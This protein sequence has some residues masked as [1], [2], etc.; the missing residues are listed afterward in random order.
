MYPLNTSK[1]GEKVHIK[2]LGCNCEEACRL[3]ELGCVEG[4]TG[5]I[6][7]K[8][9]NVILQV[10]EARLAINGALARTILVSPKPQA[11]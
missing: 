5:K 10:G 8:Q 11:L 2:C 9:A 6:V 3:R 1:V 7:S 4:T